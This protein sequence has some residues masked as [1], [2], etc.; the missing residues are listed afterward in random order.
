MTKTMSQPAAPAIVLFGLDG[1]GRPLAASFVA[2]QIALALKAATS[3]KLQTLKVETADQVDLAKQLPVGAI[4]A[5]GRAT[6]PLVSKALFDKLLA[7]KPTSADPPSGDVPAT[8]GPQPPASA[9]NQ[10]QP[11]RPPTSWAEIEAGDLVLVENWEAQQ[12]SREFAS[13]NPPTRTQ[14]ARVQERWIR[15]KISLIA[16]SS[17]QHF[18]HP[19]SSHLSKNPPSLSHVGDEYVACGRSGRL[20]ICETQVSHVLHS[21]T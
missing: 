12:S 3:L 21:I 14:D 20:K 9:S 18:Q 2:D 17:L 5:A 8:A 15:P 7:L 1:Q 19:T 16:C 13:A 4:L 10:P 11:K 6:V